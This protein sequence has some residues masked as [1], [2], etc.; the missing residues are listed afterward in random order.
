MLGQIVARGWP[1]VESYYGVGSD[2]AHW[3]GKHHEHFITAPLIV[4]NS[5]NNKNNIVAFSDQFSIIW[6]NLSQP[7]TYLVLEVLPRIV[8]LLCIPIEF[9]FGVRAWLS[10]NLVDKPNIPTR[11]HR[12]YAAEVELHTRKA[13]QHQ[14]DSMLTVLLP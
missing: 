13:T 9:K 10:H 11:K 14:P 2:S 3:H 8:H 6:R 12:S 5:E 1:N 7:G 4:G